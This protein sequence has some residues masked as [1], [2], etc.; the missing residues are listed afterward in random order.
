M[1]TS[2]ENVNFCRGPKIKN[3]KSSVRKVYV[4]KRASDF[5]VTTSLENVN[6]CQLA[7][8][9]F[10]RKSET[11]LN[12]Y[13]FRKDDFEFFILGPRQKFIENLRPV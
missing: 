12:T 3:S 11:L 6:F 1:T 10:I 2:L 5:L 9:L 8:L 7:R 13:T 4:F